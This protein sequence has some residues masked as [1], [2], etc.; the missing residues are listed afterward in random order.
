MDEMQV[1][2]RGLACPQPVIKARE[3][4]SRPQATRV[5]VLV[6]EI[7]Q[8]ENVIA[9]ARNEGWAG[10]IT[11]H[12]SDVVELVLTRNE[13][14][15]Q[16]A[17][18]GEGANSSAG[19]R[20]VALIASDRFGAGDDELGG[21]LMRAFI[22]TLWEVAPRPR[23]LIFINGG[24]KL[25]TTGSELLADIAK[26]ADDGAEVLSCGTCLDFYELKD[27]LAVGRISNMFEIVTQL[28][29]AER[30]LRP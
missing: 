3:A 19:A 5:C 7:S 15:L 2:A 24:V 30:V 21:I 10:K 23:V 11:R 29:S 17:E 4:I 22:K 16:S 9:M 8:V 27:K 18:S 6:D 14:S 13:A 28:S 20:T 25:T 26:L 12:N 1:D